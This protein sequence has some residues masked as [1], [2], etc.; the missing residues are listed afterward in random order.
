MLKL[1]IRDN[2]TGHIHEYGTDSHDSLVLND[3]GSI[4]YH[5]LQN[6][7]GTM[8]P[9]EGYT[10]VHEDGTDPRED[11]AIAKYGAEP[12]LDIGGFR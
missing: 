10:F 4:H 7:C 12:F 6:G 1:W 3:D 5:N 11:P 8:F 9:E 2:Q